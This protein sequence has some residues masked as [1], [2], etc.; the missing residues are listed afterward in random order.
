MDGKPNRRNKAVLS[1]FFGVVLT[2]DLKSLL[3]SVRPGNARSQLFVERMKA[4]V[5]SR[6]FCYTLGLPNRGFKVVRET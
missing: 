1:N 6:T 3:V 4:T 5:D 2:G